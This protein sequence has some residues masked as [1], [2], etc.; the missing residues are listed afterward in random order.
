MKRTFTFLAL[1][2]T[3][4]SSLK[5]QLFIN[6]GFTDP[7]SAPNSGWVVLNR[8]N[9]PGTTSVFQ[10]NSAV[11]AAYNG[12][13]TDF[14]GMNFNSTTGANGISTW[15]ISPTVTI[16]NGAIIQFATRTPSV[17]QIFPDRLQIRYSSVDNITIPTGST[18]LGTYTNMVLDINPNLTMN[19]T[20]VVSNGTVNGYPNTWALYTITLTGIASPST[21]R[22]AFRYF[23]D[24]GGPSGANSN[25]IGIDAVT[26]AVPCGVSVNSY[27]ICSGGTVTLSASPGIAPVSYTWNPGGS[28]SSSIVVTPGATTTYTLSYSELTGNC[29]NTT[30]TVTIGSQL[31]MNITASSSTVCAGDAVIL[32]ANSAATS[33][34]WSTGATTQTV[35]VNPTST[36]VYSVGGVSGTF[37]SLCAG[38]N[39]IQITALPLPTLTSVLDP[40][41]VCQ[42]QTYT[43]TGSGA[44]NYFWFLSSTSGSAM[45]PITFTAG[46][47]GARSYT[48]VGEG[49]NGCESDLV[50]N[51]TVQPTPTV[52]LVA[53][54]T[55]ICVNNTVSINASGAAGYA[56]SGD[57]SGASNPLIYSSATPGTKNIV[58]TGTGVEGCSSSAT[59]SI[60]VSACTG[61]EKLEN[62]AE[63]A[64]YPNPFS[65]SLHISGLEGRAEIY[66]AVGQLVLSATVSIEEE[67]NTSE[68]SKGAYILK[69]YNEKGEALKTIKLMKN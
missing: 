64:V 26:Y 65:N 15:L 5:A 2:F 50:V 48:L 10:G 56:W 53:S 62:P 22:I 38:G 1:A 51:F 58:A 66:N 28:N 8:S 12:A 43:L 11:F 54:P 35:S 44:S 42:G 6:E 9:S 7:W 3:A 68:L 59:I 23:V 33:Y 20:S 57:G 21:G 63:A 19:T 27:T 18:S 67:L 46:A 69:T 49:A 4:L 17:T 52:V 47:A 60:V 14:V 34:S 39:T 31:S 29:P 16:A 36:T 13:P 45:N 41:L 25:Y 32:T 40:T 24:N 30:A 55:V 37:P 61:I